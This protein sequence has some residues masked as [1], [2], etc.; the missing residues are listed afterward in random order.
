MKMFSRPEIYAAYSCTPLKYCIANGIFVEGIEYLDIRSFDNR[1]RFARNISSFLLMLGC[2]MKAA[3]N[4][5]IP[6][7]NAKSMVVP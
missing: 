5:I 3:T 1:R 4:C 6:T 7:M 2:P